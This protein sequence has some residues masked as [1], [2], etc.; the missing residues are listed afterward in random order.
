MKRSVVLASFVAAVCL[1]MS[2][3]DGKRKRQK[4]CECAGGRLEMVAGAEAAPDGS[5]QRLLGGCHA[6]RTPPPPPRALE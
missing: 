3:V 5:R 6:P 4:Y 1:L 2:G